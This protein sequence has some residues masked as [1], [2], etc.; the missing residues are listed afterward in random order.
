[1][2]HTDRDGEQTVPSSCPFRGTASRRTLLQ[3]FAPSRQPEC[4]AVVSAY[5]LRLMFALPQF[6]SSVELT[7]ARSPSTLRMRN[8]ER[9]MGQDARRRK[10]FLKSQTIKNSERTQPNRRNHAQNANRPNRAL[11]TSNEELEKRRQGLQN[12]ALGPHPCDVCVPTLAEIVN[13]VRVLGVPDGIT[14]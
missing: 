6:G 11:G 13:K 10:R 8:P 3:R 2:N 4:R 14:G 1:M 7:G 12:K 9:V 5:R